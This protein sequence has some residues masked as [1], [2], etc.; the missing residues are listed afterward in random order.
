[1]LRP[2]KTT[3][4][5][6][7]LIAYSGE[8][9]SANAVSVPVGT[10][11]ATFTGDTTNAGLVAAFREPF[12]RGVVAI[13]TAGA[14]IADGGTAR[15]PASGTSK[16]QIET[17][18]VNGSGT[19]DIGGVECLALGFDSSII[20]TNATKLNMF[21]SVTA[22]FRSPVA[23]IGEVS[24]SGSKLIGGSTFS[25][26]KT[27]TGAY[28]VTFSNAFGTIPVV[29]ATPVTTTA[30][31]S[32]HIKTKARNEFT[33]ATFNEA[34]SATDCAFNFIAYGSMKSYDHRLLKGPSVDIGFRKPRMLAF[35]I[36]YSG[37]VPSVDIGVG[38][39]T[40][41]D[42]DVGR[43]TL[44]Y[45]EAFAREPIV[46]ATSEHGTNYWATVHTSNA[47]SCLIEIS[48]ST[49]TLGDPTAVHI[50]VVGSDDAV[51]Y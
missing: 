3:V 12:H 37:G 23:V 29:V 30:G 11:E 15:I 19:A 14:N 32:V 16:S 20:T 43:L 44:N 17:R 51:E 25:V 6:P 26:A 34:N 5:R 28:T 41:V 39:G 36:P 2:I 42:T 35:R 47:S 9:L 10:S 40:V 33:V 48:G 45:T 18:T 4:S 50:I 8:T 21:D 46:L 31:F 7:R 49:G 22:T 13:A 27:G 24:S 1:M 38:Q